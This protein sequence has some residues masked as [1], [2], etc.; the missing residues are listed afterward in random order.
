M[1]KIITLLKSC[2]TQKWWAK[3]YEKMQKISIQFKTPFFRDR[4][5]HAHQDGRLPLKRLKSMHGI[6]YRTIARQTPTIMGV[7][8]HPSLH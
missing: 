7:E 2:E 6:N 8:N 4:G 1:E 5:T 3:K